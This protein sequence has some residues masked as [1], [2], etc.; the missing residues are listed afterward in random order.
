MNYF[1]SMCARNSHGDCSIVFYLLSVLFFN[2]TEKCEK[3]IN[4]NRLHDISARLS[5]SNSYRYI[6]FL[7]I[8]TCRVDLRHSFPFIDHGFV[9]FLSSIKKNIEYMDN[10]TKERL[11]DRTQVIPYSVIYSVL[12]RPR[13]HL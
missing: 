6:Y 1:C 9:H 7:H 10:W 8:F 12:G 2:I 5:C 11:I 4:R 3:S 13:M